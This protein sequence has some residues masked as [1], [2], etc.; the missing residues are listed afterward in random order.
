MGKRPKL[1]FEQ[2]SKL[3]LNVLMFAFNHA[4]QNGVPMIEQDILLDIIEDDVWVG[5]GGACYKW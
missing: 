4:E 5:A 3:E 2:V 1:L